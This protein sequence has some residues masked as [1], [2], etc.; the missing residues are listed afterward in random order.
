MHSTF[1]FLYLLRLA[2]GNIWPIIKESVES[3]SGS[4]Q[5]NLKCSK[6]Y[7]MKQ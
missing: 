4:V 2:E 6:I 5:G 7:E 1:S 3:G